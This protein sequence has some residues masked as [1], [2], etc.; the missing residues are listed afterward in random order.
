MTEFNVPQFFRFINPIIEILRELG[1][2]GM[3]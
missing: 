2:T 3:W 1:G